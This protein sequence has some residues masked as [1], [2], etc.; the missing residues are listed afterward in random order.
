MLERLIK[1]G[2]DHD[3]VNKT[4]KLTYAYASFIDFINEK[5]DE[6]MKT[7]DRSEKLSKALISMDV[8]NKT[9][10]Y[11]LVATI[12]YSNLSYGDIKAIFDAIS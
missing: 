7:F 5:R 4:I 3:A 10:I 1:E 2:H 11:R 9:G 8:E 12:D 6:V